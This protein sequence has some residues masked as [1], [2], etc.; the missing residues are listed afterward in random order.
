[1]DAIIALFF[2]YEINRSNKFIIIQAV[3]LIDILAFL[4]EIMFII[5]KVKS[6]FCGSLARTNL[7]RKIYLF[8]ESA[9]GH[10]EAIID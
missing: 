6:R 8:S 1:M 3:L 10:G 2:F 9:M 5:F 4:T 7:F